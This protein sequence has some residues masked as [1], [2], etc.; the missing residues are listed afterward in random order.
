M[1]GT[2][3]FNQERLRALGDAVEQ[4]HGEASIALRPLV[5]HAFGTKPAKGEA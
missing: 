3:R 2:R 5:N 4:S 1:H